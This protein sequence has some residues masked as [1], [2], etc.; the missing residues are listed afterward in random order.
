MNRL[1]YVSTVFKSRRHPEGRSAGLVY[2]RAL[3]GPIG[4]CTT[5]LMIGATAAALQG[6]P[7]WGYLVWG[8]PTAIV[9][10]TVWTQFTLSNTLAEIHLRPGQVALKSIYDVLRNRS[11]TWSPLYNV[12]ASQT[13]IEI[14]VGWTTH[15]FRRKDWP[16][17][18]RLREAAQQAYRAPTPP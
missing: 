9:V 2:T 1:T 17:Y 18:E 11:Q 6:H 3:V 10:A 16:R 15:I 4:A 8:F 5:P 7:V 14:S 13:Y 12:Q